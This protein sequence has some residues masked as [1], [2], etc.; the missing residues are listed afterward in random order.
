MFKIDAY[1]TR[2]HIAKDWEITLLKVN[3]HLKYVG[4]NQNGNRQMKE[5]FHKHYPQME[6]IQKDSLFLQEQLELREYFN[7]ER[8]VFTKKVDMKGTPFQKNV[9]DAVAKVPYGQTST[10]SEIAK[11]IG[12]EKSVRAVASAIGKN[13]LLLYIPCHRI[14][15]KNGSLSGFRDGLAIKEALLR[16][17]GNTSESF[18]NL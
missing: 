7:K 10:Y 15:G 13:P 9:W 6:W 3:H 17:E 4:I 18:S 16:L 14:I 8:N 11:N 1:W 2:F 5:W 12:A